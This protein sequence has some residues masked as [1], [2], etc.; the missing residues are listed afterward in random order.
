MALMRSASMVFGSLLNGLN[1]TF[2]YTPGR[3]AAGGTGD[4]AC[5]MAQG[6]RIIARFS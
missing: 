3:Q 2:D 4:T 1:R 6:Y 5:S